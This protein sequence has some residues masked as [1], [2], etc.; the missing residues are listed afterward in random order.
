M[1]GNYL[2]LETRVHPSTMIVSAISHHKSLML[3]F[4]ETKN[5]ILIEPDTLPTFITQQLA[6]S[7]TVQVINVLAQKMKISS[8]DSHRVVEKALL[9]IMCHHN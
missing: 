5:H 3:F 9:G 2:V 6:V 4:L 1:I 8:K 7:A